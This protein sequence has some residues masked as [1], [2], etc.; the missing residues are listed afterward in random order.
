MRDHMSLLPRSMVAHAVGLFITAVLASGCQMTVGVSADMAQQHQFA[1]TRADDTPKPAGDITLFGE[2]GGDQ[3]MFRARAARSLKQHT[4]TGEGRDFGPNLDSSGMMMVFAS[5]RHSP[6][7]DIYFKS[8]NG[9]T[10]TQLTSDPGSDVEPSFS[11]D[12]RRIAFASDRAGTWDIWVMDVDGR[13]LTQISRGPAQDVHPSW[14]PDGMRL[15]YCSLPGAN[16]EWELWVV[17]H[18]QPGTRQFIGYGL[19][20]AW[21]P[22]ADRIA[23]QRARNRG[24]R[25]FSVWTIDL[26]AG[27]AMYPTEVASSPE[28]ALVLPSWSRDGTQLSYCAIKPAAAEAAEGVDSPAGMLDGLSDLWMIDA[29]GKG[30]VQLTDGTTANYGPAWSPDGRI[31]FTS[32]RGGEAETVWSLMPL[33]RPATAGAPES[34]AERVQLGLRR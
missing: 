22:T 9:A 18:S 34:P 1:E 25:W 13:N 16:R 20:P 7:S 26:V 33:R 14:S 28:H 5:T 32:T 12:G 23:F 15:V 4:F 2:L 8:V 30:R 24:S 11:P 10:V 17:D 27:E 21:S 19:F 29:D 3:V 6:R 31:Y